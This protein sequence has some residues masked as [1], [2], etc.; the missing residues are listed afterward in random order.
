M[1]GITFRIIILLTDYVSGSEIAINY[2]VPISHHPH[3]VGAT[4]TTR[5]ANIKVSVQNTVL[6][7]ACLTITLD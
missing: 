1:V 6:P 3:P 4:Q 5:Y 2:P 7:M